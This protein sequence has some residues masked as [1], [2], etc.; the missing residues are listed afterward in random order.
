MRKDSYASNMK[1]EK[2]YKF[3]VVCK[4]FIA[5]SFKRNK[6]IRENL[7]NIRKQIVSLKLRVGISDLIFPQGTEVL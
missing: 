4:I 7:L 3:K 6:I 5:Q 1:R 2:I